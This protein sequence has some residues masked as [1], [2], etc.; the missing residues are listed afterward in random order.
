MSKDSHKDSKAL[1]ILLLA[2]L[3]SIT[4]HNRICVNENAETSEMA[5]FSKVYVIELSRM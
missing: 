4:C 2:D 5:C 3:E 1:V